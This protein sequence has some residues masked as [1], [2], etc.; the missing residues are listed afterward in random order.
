MKL[1]ADTEAAR[2]ALEA[3]VRDRVVRYYRRHGIQ[4]VNYDLQIV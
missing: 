2:A 1:A 4:S 3:D